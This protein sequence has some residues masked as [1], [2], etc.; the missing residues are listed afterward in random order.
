ML[1]CVGRGLC[2]GLITHPKE[3]YQCLNK[4]KNLPCEAAKGPYKDCRASEGGRETQRTFN[5][6]SVAMSVGPAMRVTKLLT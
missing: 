5:I 1:P 6:V 4:F 3:S 2:D